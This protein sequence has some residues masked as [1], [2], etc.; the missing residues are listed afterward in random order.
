MK[1]LVV[2]SSVCLICVVAA[3][4]ANDRADGPETLMCQRGKLLFSDDFDN[5]L[6]KAW[7]TA[8]G[9]WEVA[10]GVIQGSE[11]KSDMHGAVTRHAMTLHDAVIQYSFKLDG[12]RATTFSINDAKGHCCRVLI[13]RAGF[14]VRKDDHDHDGPDRAVNLQ[15]VKTPLQD[16]Q[17]HTLVIELHGPELLARLDGNQVGYGS[18]EAIDVDKTNFGLTVGG[19][20]ASFKNLRVW[21]A[22]VKT[23]WPATKAKFAKAA[24]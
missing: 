17:W 4:A 13:N 7:R 22:T 8:K 16:G 3:R 21:D 12:A 14:S 23:D 10:G 19:E 24:Q 1:T 9:K 6:G 11:L 18:Y 15:T 20:S 2:M 5:P